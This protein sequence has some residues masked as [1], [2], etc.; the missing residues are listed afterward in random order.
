[1]EEY[2]SFLGDRL[3]LGLINRKAV[4]PDDFVYRNSPPAEL[5]DEQEMKSKRP[6]EMKPA[7][8][9]AFV[10]AYEQMMKRRIFYEPLGKTI[11]Y[12]WLIQ[13]QVR[14]FGKYLENQDIEYKPF[15]WES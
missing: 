7:I 15:T 14:Q 10:S 5:I 8:R 3:V 11:E 9:R 2:R 4:T 1:V 13:N 6:V 12:R